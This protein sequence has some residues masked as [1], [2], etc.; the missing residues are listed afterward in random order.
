MLEAT[1]HPAID[2][3]AIK[4]FN[5]PADTKNVT[6]ESEIVRRGY[7]E[8]CSY[9]TTEV[10]VRDSKYNELGRTATDLATIMREILDMAGE[11]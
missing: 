7:C 1:T 9:E 8:T 5:L 6:V 4:K 3:W 10:I 2:K 11:P